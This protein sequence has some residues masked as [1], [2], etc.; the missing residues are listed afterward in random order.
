MSVAGGRKPIFVTGLYGSLIF[1]TFSVVGMGVGLYAGRLIREYIRVLVVSGTNGRHIGILL[2]V[3][4]LSLI[5]I[6]MRIC[7]GLSS[8]LADRRWSYNIMSISQD[9]TVALSTSAF[10]FGDIRHLRRL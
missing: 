2:L 10:R 9:G 5:I 8:E 4:I 7:I 3:S 6:G 1:A